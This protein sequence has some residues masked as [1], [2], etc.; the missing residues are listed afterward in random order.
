MRQIISGDKQVLKY[1]WTK[2]PSMLRYHAKSMIPMFYGAEKFATTDYLSG[3]TVIYQKQRDKGCFEITH[4]SGQT[5]FPASKKF[6]IDFSQW[7][8]K[9]PGDVDVVAMSM[10]ENYQTLFLLLRQQRV[11]THKIGL[12]L[13]RADI[14][15]RRLNEELDVMGISLCNMPPFDFNTKITTLGNRLDLICSDTWRGCEVVSSKKLNRLYNMTITQGKMIV[16]VPLFSLGPI[17]RK[18]KR[19]EKKSDEWTSASNPVLIQALLM[20]DVEYGRLDGSGIIGAL[21]LFNE[22]AH[23]PNPNNWPER[24]LKVGMSAVDDCV[25]WSLSPLHTFPM[26]IYEEHL[27]YYYGSSAM[28]TL[29]KRRFSPFLV[30]TPSMLPNMWPDM[31]SNADLPDDYR[32]LYRREAVLMRDFVSEVQAGKDNPL[33]PILYN[34]RNQF[35]IQHPPAFDIAEEHEIEKAGRCLLMKWR[36]G[37]VTYSLCYH[38]FHRKHIRKF[39]NGSPAIY[40]VTDHEVG[41]F[42]YNGAGECLADDGTTKYYHI[43]GLEN[44][45]SYTYMTNVKLTAPSGSTLRFG[46]MSGSPVKP[47]LTSISW[48]EIEPH[49]EV[50]F[51]AFASEDTDN[52]WEGA[53]LEYGLEIR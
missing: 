16:T 11:N 45:S 42:I 37:F 50:L 27:Q 44:L 53:G 38:N 4:V 52:H 7:Y 36:G 8:A 13:A 6:Y 48:D 5:V 30:N 15:D 14:G 40:E 10:D 19:E 9:D 18:R 26:E 22:I 39:T 49:T 34:V 3:L 32:Q 35:Y 46:H 47:N 1:R 2:R 41:D 20:I 33:K 12:W 43:F 29:A 28:S 24:P 17:K 25:V 51:T 23:S 21:P 31:W